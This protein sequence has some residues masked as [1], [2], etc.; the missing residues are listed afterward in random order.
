MLRHG[1]SFQGIHPIK[2]GLSTEMHQFN[3]MYWNLFSEIL[4]REVYLKKPC[5]YI[6]IKK[7]KNI[8]YKW[9]LPRNSIKLRQNN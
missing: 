3:I 4:Y 5:R 8:I 9:I 6:N 1:I 7:K 2:Y